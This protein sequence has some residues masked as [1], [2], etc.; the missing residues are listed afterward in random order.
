MK[1]RN[2]YNVFIV[3]QFGFKENYS[4]TV[5]VTQLCEYIRNETDQ[6]NNVCAIFVNLAKAFDTVNHEILL[7][8]LEQYG[9]RG[10]AN[11]VIPD[12]LSNRKQYVQANSV[13]SL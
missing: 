13:S 5:A 2:K 10:S 11:K 4:T 3:A 9:I 12:Y 8:K 7:S 1:F 6:N